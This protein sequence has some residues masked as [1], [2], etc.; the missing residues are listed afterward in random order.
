MCIRDRLEGRGPSAEVLAHVFPERPVYRPGDD[1]HLKGY[2]RLRT[3]GR[4]E[5]VPMSG[6]L[7]VEGPGDLAWK[8]PVELSAAGAF[9]H[10][11]NEKDLPT[12]T[13]RAHFED[14]KR[15]NRYGQAR[16]SIEA[17]RIPTFEVTLHAPDQTALD[18]P[19]DVSLTA[20]Y[21]AGGKVGGQPVQWRVSQ[22]PAT[23]T[24]KRREG[25]LYSSD[26]R[27]SRTD[28]FQSTPR[29]EKSDTTSDEGSSGLS[30]NPTLEPTAQSRTYVVEATVTGP[31]DQTVTATRSILALPPFV[32]GVKA[33]RFL[34]RAKEIAPEV[35]VVGHDGELLAD[36]DVT[37]RLLRREWH[38]HLRASDF[39]DGVA[40]YLTDVVDTKV[41]ET[42]V[43]SAATPV[44]VRLPIDRAGV[45]VVEMEAR[46][47]LD[48]SLIH[49]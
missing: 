4:L 13:Y 21:Y 1:V 36:K 10:K 14:Q 35:I 11:F 24:P 8:Y 47:R 44:V 17:Y 41:S 32:L 46:D 12:G 34:E 39:S 19:F 15:E 5:I 26:G 7:V 31:D 28:R 27:F 6:W 23:W 16:F 29:L 40:R 49:I 33:P 38:S 43:K 42:T 37:V 2:V 25:F 22:F 48:L 45:Y 20:T 30:L 9:Y 3:Q 18:K